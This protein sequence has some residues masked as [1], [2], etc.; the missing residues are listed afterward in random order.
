MEELKKILEKIDL[1]LNTK[2][3]NQIAEDDARNLQ[4]YKEDHMLLYCEKEYNRFKLEMLPLAAELSPKF[5]IHCS[6][7]QKTIQDSP[8]ILTHS[9][10]ACGSI[11]IKPNFALEKTIEGKTTGI[12]IQGIELR[13]S[14]DFQKAGQWDYHLKVVAVPNPSEFN[15]R[16]LQTGSHFP[17]GSELILIDLHK[18]DPWGIE[19]TLLGELNENLLVKI[20]NHFFVEE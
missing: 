2:E 3:T 6:D 7:W 13:I 16:T 15:G 4:K 5:T 10:Y 8:R 19:E 11:W 9:Y 17:K 20:L 14:L 12:I 1:R 18:E